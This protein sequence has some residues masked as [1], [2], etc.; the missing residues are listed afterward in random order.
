MDKYKTNI[1]LYFAQCTINKHEGWLGKRKMYFPSLLVRDD[2]PR[3][4]AGRYCHGDESLALRRFL[5]ILVSE[6]RVWTSWGLLSRRGLWFA[7]QRTLQGSQVAIRCCY[8]NISLSFFL[9]CSSTF[10]VLHETHGDRLTAG[11]IMFFDWFL[12]CFFSLNSGHL[13]WK[14]TVQIARK[15]MKEQEHKR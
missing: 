3:V 11:M 15:T 9:S 12:F 4:A 6:T 1:P 8:L 2:R 7:A 5:L 14:N 13:A 10:C